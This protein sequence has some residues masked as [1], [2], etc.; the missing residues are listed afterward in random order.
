MEDDEGEA[1]NAGSYGNLAQDCSLPARPYML[2]LANHG[3]PQIPEQS[4]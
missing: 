2:C 1:L 3:P 4:M